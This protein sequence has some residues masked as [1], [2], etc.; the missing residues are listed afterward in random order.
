MKSGGKERREKYKKERGERLRSG[1][2]GDEEIEKK[3]KMYD[4][5]RNER[6]KVAIRTL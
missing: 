3:E 2:K 4:I 5:Q 1:M 6:T